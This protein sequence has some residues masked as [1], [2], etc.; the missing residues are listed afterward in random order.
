MADVK[1]IRDRMK[2]NLQTITGLFAYDTMPSI[3]VVPC[4]IV[5]PAPGVF[6]AE[7]SMDG[8]EDLNLVVTVLLTKVVDAASQDNADTYLSEGSSNIA[9]AIDSGSTTDWDYAVA[10]PARNYGRYVFGDG[11]GQQQFLGFE[12]PVVVGVS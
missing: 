3:P 6:L 10:L 12:I 2:T 5:A 11:D 9:N 7:V 1:A 8:V 4:A